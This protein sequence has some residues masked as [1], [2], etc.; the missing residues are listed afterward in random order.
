MSG[1]L[2]AWV[3]EEIERRGWSQG[4][5]ARRSGI[6]RPLIS[7]VLAGDVPPSADFGIK[8]AHA[9]GEAPEKVLRLAGILPASED[10]PT[11]TQIVDI[12]RNLSP[13][14]RRQV[15]EFAKFLYRRGEEE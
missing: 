4:E 5:L 8:I 9:L 12:M 1:R 10:D 13:E 15:V 6:S 7:Q 2:K 14:Q 3:S 11:L